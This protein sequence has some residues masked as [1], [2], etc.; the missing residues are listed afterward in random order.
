MY[1]E[2]RAF[3][4]QQVYSV[5]YTSVH[6]KYSS[7]SYRTLKHC[8]SLF[9]SS[10]S[11]TPSRPC[12]LYSVC[13]VQYLSFCMCTICSIYRDV[14][15]YVYV[16]RYSAMMYVY[17]VQYL[18]CCMCALYTIHRAVCVHCAVMGAQTKRPKT[19]RPQ[20]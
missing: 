11:I 17:N 2:F 15:V 16:Y 13:T 12:R 3:T 19:K 4:P 5:L 18:P 14:Y 10:A 9:Y 7:T 1:Q 6:S 8:Y 20:T